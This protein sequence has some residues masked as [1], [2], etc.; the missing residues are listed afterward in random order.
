[1]IRRPAIIYLL[2][3]GVLLFI[4]LRIYLTSFSLAK[5][6][7][8][9]FDGLRAFEDIRT[10]LSFGF[11]TPGSNGHEKTR[12]WIRTELEANGWNVLNQEGIQS[13]HPIDNIIGIRDGDSP[14][15]I[16]GAH[17]DTRLISDKDP[18]LGKRME[19]VPGANDGASGVAVL[20]E[21]ARSLPEDIRSVWLVFFD[22]EDNGRIETWDWSLGSRFFVS[23]LNVDPQAVIIVDMVADKD[24]NI[25]YEK[26]SDS[27]LRASIWQTAED[28]GYGDVFIPREKHSILDDHTSFLEEG[29]PAVDLI[30]IDY[31]FW[32]TTLDTIDKVS[33]DSLQAVGAT[34]WTWIIQQKDG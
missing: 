15:I 14:R 1:M 12:D 10:Q 19:P 7:L 2:L 13:E 34:L 25:Y 23:N 22:A 17:Y 33:P 9:G 24:L 5:T 31:P 20:I 30:D 27:V 6:G 3:I 26:N 8:E 18:E 11:R 4:V 32:H 16:I 29:I 28:L 21:L